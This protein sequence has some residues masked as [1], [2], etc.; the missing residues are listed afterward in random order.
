MYHIYI[1]PLQIV[2]N[3]HTIVSVTSHVVVKYSWAR[4]V[5]L[6]NGLRGA[7]PNPKPKRPAYL[8]YV[9]FPMERM[10]DGI[11]KNRMEA[12]E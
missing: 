6:R 4:G 3:S 12:E 1:H 8:P 10:N 9:A 7:A 2:T 5:D 11:N